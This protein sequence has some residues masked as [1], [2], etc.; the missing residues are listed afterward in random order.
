MVNGSTISVKSTHLYSFW[1]RIFL[2]PVICTRFVLSLFKW[3]FAIKQEMDI[4]SEFSLFSPTSRNIGLF[5]SSLMFVSSYIYR[6][7]Q[8]IVISFSATLYVYK[9]IGCLAFLLISLGGKPWNTYLDLNAWLEAAC[10]VIQWGNQRITMAARV[11]ASSE[12][13]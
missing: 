11:P 2:H 8:F 3:G 9:D 12:G 4:F 1:Q 10:L 13:H 7:S 5:I 6:I